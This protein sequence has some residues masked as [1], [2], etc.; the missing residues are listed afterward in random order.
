MT[1]R[2][3]TPVEAEYSAQRQRRRAVRIAN[4]E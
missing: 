3:D 1:L 4:D 2:D